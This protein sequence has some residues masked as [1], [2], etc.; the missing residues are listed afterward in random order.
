MHIHVPSCF[1]GKRSG[2]I[3]TKRCWSH[4]HGQP[5]ENCS[6]SWG[7]SNLRRT[8]ASSAAASPRCLPRLQLGEVVDG[9]MPRLG[10]CPPLVTQ[11]QFQ[12]LLPLS[13]M[14][15]FLG[16]DVSFL[17]ASKTSKHRCQVIY[18]YTDIIHCKCKQ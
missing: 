14:V 10:L 7:P 15:I 4:L 11:L 3:S 12:V 13:K 1:W 18:L 5:P 8:R 17:K 2:F 9:C 16:Q 6:C